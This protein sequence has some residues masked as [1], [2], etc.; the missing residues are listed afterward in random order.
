MP[1]AAATASPLQRKVIVRSA[2]Q[3]TIAPAR[4]LR[5]A[6]RVISYESPATA[7]RYRLVKAAVMAATRKSSRIASSMIALA[8]GNI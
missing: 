1:V 7:P 3:M 2:R 8:I 6:K 5:K 4:L